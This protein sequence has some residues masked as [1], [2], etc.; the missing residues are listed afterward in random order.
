MGTTVAFVKPV[1]QVYTVITIL[2][3]VPKGTHA[4]MGEF[5]WMA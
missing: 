4:R 2:I 5:V 1:L 3:I